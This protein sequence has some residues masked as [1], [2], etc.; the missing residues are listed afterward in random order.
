MHQKRVRT[1]GHVQWNV[2]EVTTWERATSVGSRARRNATRLLA[3]MAAPA[4]AAVVDALPFWISAALFV[5]PGVF[6]LLNPAEEGAEGDGT[7]ESDITAVGGARQAATR[8]HDGP[9]TT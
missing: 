3:A 2:S 5:L 4:G 6:A 7:G 1:M 9:D 8:S